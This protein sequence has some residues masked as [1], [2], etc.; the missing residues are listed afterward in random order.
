MAGAQD[1]RLVA[2]DR[3]RPPACSSKRKNEDVEEAKEAQLSRQSFA[4]EAFRIRGAIC[5][6]VLRRALYLHRWANAHPYVAAQTSLHSLFDKA[7]ALVTD[8]AAVD[9]EFLAAHR[10]RRAALEERG[11]TDLGWVEIAVR[12]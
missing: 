2:F 4:D 7:I 10:L 6:E 11:W 12:Q 8:V 9:D 3:A 5:A 1:A